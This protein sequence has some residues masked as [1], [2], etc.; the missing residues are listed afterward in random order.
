[1]GSCVQHTA[2]STY[3]FIYIKLLYNIIIWTIT[4]ST[5]KIITFLAPVFLFG[6]INAIKFV[7]RGY[8]LLDPQTGRV[9]PEQGGPRVNF[10][11]PS[12][13]EFFRGSNRDA[14][15]IHQSHYGNREQ[16][17]LFPNDFSNN[18]Y[19]NSNHHSSNNDNGFESSV[20]PHFQQKRKVIPYNYK[21]YS[22]SNNNGFKSSFNSN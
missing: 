7:P 14:R 8:Q 19:F 12:T 10:A 9:L 3:Q 21:R 5:M 17:R 15:Q 2:P 20:R 16:K 22:G 11:P 1:M 18:F 4:N 6:S 13:D